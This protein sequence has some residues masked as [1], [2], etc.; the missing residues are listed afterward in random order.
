[1]TRDDV[2]RPG[3]YAAIPKCLL[4]LPSRTVSPAAKLVWMA[5]VERF[6]DKDHSWPGA[7]LIANDTGLTRKG[8]QKAVD[9]L[10]ALKLLT[11]EPG[12]RGGGSNRYWLTEFASVLSSLANGVRH[13]S[14][15]GTLASEQSTLGASEQSSP[16]LPNT[17]TER[18]TEGTTQD[19]A[20]A[21]LGAS[22]P[23]RPVGGSTQ[24]V[25]SEDTPPATDTTPPA[26]RAVTKPSASSRKP[27][28]G[29]PRKSAA[30]KQ[31]APVDVALVCA[32]LNS[33]RDH[34]TSGPLNW[35]RYRRSDTDLGVDQWGAQQFA[36]YYWFQVSA[37]RANHKLELTLPPFPKLLG[38]MGNLLK[39]MP[40][41]RL[42]SIITYVVYYFDVI[43]WMLRRAGNTVYLDENSLLNP[44]VQQSA[45]NLMAMTDIERGGL[46]AQFKQELGLAA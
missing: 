25:G 21:P 6:G 30:T 31:Q 12:Q 40:R 41:Q 43:R 35:E 7:T 5:V 46:V 11:V 15:R 32:D 37:Y 10:R 36:G 29:A 45:N 17:T 34:L 2:L 38:H 1:M 42:W 39:Q 19:C 20:A 26:A 22:G 44:L 13:P 14:E 16:E 33:M 9:E 4:A 24:A 23:G 28:A 8:V 27:A 18:T 3:T